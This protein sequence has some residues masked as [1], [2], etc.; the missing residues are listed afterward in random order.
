M[1]NKS[2]D[3]ILNFNL[4]CCVGG[5]F[6]ALFGL[7]SYL[8]KEGF[9]VT[10]PLVSLCAGVFL[11]PYGVRL[12]RPHE[13][14]SS[15]EALATVTLCFTR[16]VLGIQ[17]VI[18]GIQL[19]SRYLKTEW[20]SLAILLGPGMLGMWVITSF[21]VWQLVPDL[22]LVQSLIVGACVTPTDPVLSNSIVKG[23]FADKHMSRPLQKIIIAES[24]ANDGLGYLFLF[25]P[26]YLV[27]FA[28]Q[29]GGTRTAVTSFLSVTCLYT[30]LLSVVYGAV[31]GWAAKHL[32]FWADRRRLVDKESLHLFAI[33]LALLIIGTVGLIDADD[34][35]A[36]F[37]A[38]NTF[39]WDD[40]FREQTE[41]DSLQP[42]MDFLLN[43]AV[44]MW[45]GAVCPWEK[46][47]S[48]DVIPSSRLILLGILVLLLRRLPVIIALQKQIPQ[49]RNIRH[50]TIMG[51]FGPIGIS[52]I[53]YLYVTQDFL[54][55]IQLEHP[56]REDCIALAQVT[57]VIVWFLVISSVVVHG[58]AIP[59][60]SLALLSP[61]V[62][63]SI[64]RLG[65][66]KDDSA[67]RIDRDN[68]AAET[69]PLL[70]EP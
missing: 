46:F 47:F 31:A 4:V 36:C 66:D 58:L 10:E 61:R 30:I 44:F 15:P 2:I 40:W 48:G 57:A 55:R 17:L 65:T 39:T 16:L 29:E 60:G 12:I 19:P 69:Q 56:E 22:G 14:A 28:G 49:I 18:A 62:F 50:A 38:G 54:L 70:P 8:L 64:R 25:L 5:G 68:T 32:L 7:V 11:S 45:L 63:N 41:H 37:V 26:L 20:R 43:V 35:L 67:R 59:L 42:I 33:A 34:V 13:Y 6:I 27:K 3:P 1:V 24:G 51:F 21:L 52:A 23:T 53:F 9:Y